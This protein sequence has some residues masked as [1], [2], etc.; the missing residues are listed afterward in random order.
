MERLHE[1]LEAVLAGHGIEWYELDYWK[2]DIDLYLG[3]KIRL[4]VSVHEIAGILTAW[5]VTEHG[6][7]IGSDR[8]NTVRPEEIRIKCEGVKAV[9]HEDY[10]Q[11]VILA[12]NRVAEGEGA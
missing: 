7:Q 9:Y 12:A 11:A 2:N 3:K 5:L 1:R 8:N 4:D 10:T 6:A